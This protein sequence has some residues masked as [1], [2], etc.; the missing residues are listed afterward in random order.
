[1]WVR[2]MGAIKYTKTEFYASL[3]DDK[4]VLYG[5]DGIQGK[6]INAGAE[7]A[8]WVKSPP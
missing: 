1:M 8:I 6:F 7:D 2:K 4:V 3:V 5:E